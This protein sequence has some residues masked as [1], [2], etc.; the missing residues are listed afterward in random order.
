MIHRT[1]RIKC[2]WLLGFLN[3]IFVLF[4]LTLPHLISPIMADT[5][6]IIALTGQDTGYSE[7]GNF[8]HG[9][10][11]VVNAAGLVSFE[12]STTG[13]S[14]QAIFRS[15]GSSLIRIAYESQYSG[16]E[17]NMFF[18]HFLDSRINATG[19]AAFYATTTGTSTQGIFQGDGSSL[20]R[21]AYQGQDASITGGG[22]I[23]NLE[24][25]LINIAGQIVFRAQTTG[26][27]CSEAIYRSEGVSFLPIAYQ[28]KATGYSE[29]ENFIGFADHLLNASGQV[30]FCSYTSG[31]STAGVFR[32]GADNLTR[33]AYQGQSTSNSESGNFISFCDMAF[34][35]SGQVAF[36]SQTTGTSTYGIYRGDGS[37]LTCIAYQGQNSGNSESGNF[38]F[39]ADPLI[40]TSGQVAFRASTTGTSTVGIFRNDGAC[41]TRIVGHGQLS[42]DGNDIFS[43]FFEIVG[44]TQGGTVLFY[45]RFSGTA[46]D[47]ALFL[48]DGQEIRQVT[49]MGQSLAGSTFTEFNFTNIGSEQC[50]T[51][52]VNDYGQVTFQ[53][54]LANGKSGIFLFTPDTLH[55]RSTMS[56]NWD[57]LSN[58]TLSLKP[59]PVHDLWIDPVS[60]LTVTGPAGNESVKSLTLG[61]Q[62]SGSAILTLNGTGL[63][64]IHALTIQSRGNLDLNTGFL[65]ADSI[66][67]AGVLT[68][69][70]GTTLS[71]S[72]MLN[73]ASATFG[74]DIMVSSS[75][76][77]Q[78]TMSIQPAAHLTVG[79]AGLLNTAMLTL[80]NATIGGSGTIINT[81]SLVGCGQISN[82][83]LNSGVIRAQ[84]GQ[85]T[86][87]GTNNANTTNGQIEIPSS[88]SLFL[89]QG[90]VA[91]VG[92]ISLSGGTLDTNNTDLS[93]IGTLAGNGTIRTK[94]LDNSG[95]IN[96]SNADTAF[97][98][99]VTNN[100]NLTITGNT[101]SFYGYV[102][103]NG[104]IKT[105]SAIVNYY[106]G[107]SLNG[108]YVSDPSTQFFSELTITPTGA[109]IGNQGDVFLVNGDLI[110]AGTV[111][112]G[113]GSRMVIQNGDFVQTGGSFTIGKDASFVA[114]KL[115]V[116]GGSIAIAPD[117]SFNSTLDYQSPVDS[118]IAG[119]LSGDGN[120]LTLITAPTIKLTL[121]NSNSYTGATMIESGILEL[122]E[123][124]QIANSSGV[125]TASAGVFQINSGTHSV[126]MINGQGT[127]NVIAGSLTTSSIIQSTLIIGNGVMSTMNGASMSHVP[128]PSTLALMLTA[129]LGGLLW[130][131]R[132]PNF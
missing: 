71:V 126:K 15:D 69:S 48:S 11:P 81:G 73:T 34:S 7:N 85:L 64:V 120:I 1:R 25:P 84:N 52:A 94:S 91:N 115:R 13:S 28:G 47:K 44:M 4:F 59:G 21:I 86:I 8:E 112:L 2:F 96:V 100:G 78:G 98:G 68:Q 121:S 56:G 9:S 40:N 42:P 32:A 26:P 79:G 106:A 6:I 67:N 72:T 93:N 50:G 3:V 76:E 118:T 70:T 65:T 95:Q 5:T 45:T 129:T 14:T 103:N 88:A 66:G 90:M 113:N 58:W 22:I 80:D 105:S 38:S 87:S 49:R 110:S 55:Y 37:D 114:Q 33:I 111:Q 51:S 27:T 119:N 41:F 102:T 10:Y 23:D 75:F 124:G 18:N 104:T 43:N 128:E 77:N 20:T 125:T 123:F 131:R 17:E 116:G 108:T 109:L 62:L 89:S 92:T 130:W 30:A 83:I 54:L 99:S 82:T 16:Y 74:G 122:S 61:T 36:C 63:T 97:Y 24:S 53:G 12:A 39:V 132:Q 60:S 35:A 117:A 19:Q 29:N 31:T 101:T 57:L 127:T 46:N 107:Q